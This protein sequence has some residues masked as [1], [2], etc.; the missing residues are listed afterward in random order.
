M[1][2]VVIGH[3]FNSFY[4][5]Q[6]LNRRYIIYKD[7][8]SVKTPLPVLLFSGIIAQSDYKDQ[9]LEVLE[10]AFGTIIEETPYVKFNHTDYYEKEMGKNLFRKWVAFSKL[11]NPEE[12]SSIKHTTNKLEMEYAVG[13]NRVFNLDPGYVS[14]Q[15]M[16]LVTTKSYSHRIYLKDGIYGEVT[17]IYRKKDGFMPLQ[18]TY[19]DYRDKITLDFFNRARRL[20]K[21]LLKKEKAN[22]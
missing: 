7:M 8:G 2:I 20:L 13:G 12:I 6:L 17:L 16:V 5:L 21:E 22:D 19:P 10:K 11:I 1:D 18:W 4:Y 3:T 9:A 15:N 14:L